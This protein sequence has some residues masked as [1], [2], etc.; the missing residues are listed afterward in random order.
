MKERN[1]MS[2]T[3]LQPG[4]EI[5]IIASSGPFKKERLA[6]ALK[7]FTNA[8]YKIKLGKHIYKTDRYIAGSI[9]ERL[10][11]I[12]EMFQSKTIKGIFSARGGFGTTQLL[13]FLN[14]SMIAENPKPYF[15]LSD[16]TAL[17][18]ALWENSNLPTIS[19]YS[20]TFRI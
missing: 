9:K 6:P 13:P 4:D 10:Q 2:H 7:Y 11:D 18:I 17:Q 3:L 15:G 20:N 12:H 14:Y 5:G 1:L 19:I 16:T 8:G